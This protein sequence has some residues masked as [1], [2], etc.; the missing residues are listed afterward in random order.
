M[1]AKGLYF[2]WFLKDIFSVWR[3][4][5]LEFFLSIF[6][7]HCSTVFQLALTTYLLLSISLSLC[8]PCISFIF[9]LAVFKILFKKSLILC[10]LLFLHVSCV[11][12][13]YSSWDYEILVTAHLPSNIF[14]LQ[15]LQIHVHLTS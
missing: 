14:A 7:I 6:W 10:D 12:D 13:Y 11:W 9:P 8:R 15:E 2:I 1:S 4:L 3:I 5:G